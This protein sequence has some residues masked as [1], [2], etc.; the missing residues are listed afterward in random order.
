MSDREPNHES[1]R[2]GGP[3]GWMVHNPVAANLLMVVILVGGLL[4][5]LS[6]KQEVFPEFE[7]DAVV[8]T[9]AY[10][11]ASPAEVEQGIVLAVE[12]A[13]NGIDDVK[14]VS[15]VAA[16]G[17]ASVT[18]ELL[19]GADVDA[20]LDDVTNAVSR[21]TTLPDE[22]EEPTIAAASMRRQ[23]VSLVIAG[24]HDEATLHQLAER[25]R[26]ALLQRE[27]IT[28]VEL[29][30]VRPLE[31][32]IEVPREALESYGLSL[33]DI[34]RQV[35]AASIEVPGGG[36]DTGAGEILVR[37]ADRKRTASDFEAIILRGS[38][39]GSR[40]RLGDIATVTDGYA[41]TDQASYYN[42][43]R[44]V[45]VTAYRVGD[46]TPMSV[47]AAVRS[48]ADE[49][50]QE[51]P[52]ATT[53][54]VWND[55]SEL[56]SARIDLLTRNAWMGF[57]LVVVILGLFLRG[58][59]AAWVALGIPL[60][61]LG[62]FSLL[63]LFGLSVNMITLFALIVTLGLVVDD[64]I[65][66]G[67]SIHSKAEAGM[68][69][70]QAAV[71][72]TK[73]MAAPVTF[74]ILTTI[75]AFG[76]LFF[77]PG[78]SGKFFIL[79]P[80]VV[81]AVLIFSWIE[82]FFILP[83]HLGHG[84]GRK[85]PGPGRFGTWLGRLP[86][87]VSWLLDW[88]V[89]RLYRPAVA[90]TLR[91]RPVV[92]AT[93]FAAL[94][95]AVS[96]VASGTVPFSFFPK[97]EGDLVT[98]S[99]RLPYGAPLAGTLEVREQLE[100]AA[101]RATASEPGAVRGMFTRVGEGPEGGN[102]GRREVG[103]HLVTIELA[104]VPSEQRSA[105]AREVSDAWALET[106]T[107]AGLESV[108]FS[109]SVGP[110]AGSAIDIQLVDDDPEQLVAASRQLTDLL[111]GYSQLTNVSNSWSAGKPQLDY[112]LLPQAHDLGLTGADI[113]GQLRGA[114]Y[115]AEA[116]REQRDRNELRVMVRLPE[117]QQQS[118]Q[119]LSNFRVKTM[120]GAFVPLSDVAQAERGWSPTAIR[121]EGGNRTV[122]V[123]AELA[124][125]VAS[126]REVLASLKDEGLPE[127][128]DQYAGL[129][130]SFVGEQREQ[131]ETFASL[132][133]SYLFAMFVIFALLAIP[134]RS[135][136]LPLVIM[137]AIPF[138]IVGAVVG[139]IVMGY[140]LSIISIF[141]IIAL[142]GVVVN[143]TL[144]LINQAVRRRR[145]GAS[146]AEAAI[147]AG[148][149]RFR[150]I[151]LTSLTTFFGLVPIIFE[152]SVQARFLVPMA[153]SLGFG[154]LFATFIA[155]LLVPAS[156]TLAE[157]LRDWA[158]RRRTE[159]V[160]RQSTEA[161]GWQPVASGASARPVSS[162]SGV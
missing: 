157:D 105:T 162:P 46:E 150:P 8:V 115:G 142:S 137:A 34:A 107:L 53:V 159:P 73:E 128:T 44:A 12:E 110:G 35:G 22:A 72:G 97:L 104:L 112:R 114:F 156:Y 161:E 45:R 133:R 7:L 20:V 113:A 84:G 33:D 92:L 5:L 54:A 23:V 62:A 87:A 61:F 80:S 108:V 103:S 116:L 81:V 51:L 78:V 10:P 63:P 109:S 127:L 89:R 30:G 43:Q 14:R 139:H 66:V 1:R 70:L 24:E 59:L 76:P 11:G 148:V 101:R 141:G 2:R 37:M 4:G 64:A 27:E 19:L 95:V 32:S 48:Y 140:G 86:A 71:E 154:V 36:V 60:S 9:V 144:V 106:P 16:E 55:D 160:V 149:S 85:R 90:W 68:P 96:L 79:I 6:V 42:G 83:A 111:R 69:R 120:S 155:L 58:R 28:Q 47:A 102:D 136:L 40:L 18:A 50:R 130:W 126:P 135:Y 99:A 138:G 158:R 41:D 21:L 131:G 15:S 152:T 29:E 65:I 25:A 129:T 132:G 143:D 38:R 145:Q 74:S 151:V 153:L 88:Q 124:P 118:E 147:E 67:E 125:G 57:I 17:Q 94:V 13:I 98:A 91:W 26:S 146:A 31:V 39:D 77:V 75:V 93:A 117:G 56:L 3:I 100:T 119:D 121:R 49:L 123:T 122:N 52:A 82:S 134:L